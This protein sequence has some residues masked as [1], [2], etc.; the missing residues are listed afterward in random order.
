ML[1]FY[2]VL[3]LPSAAFIKTQF[4]S[5]LVLSLWTLASSALL[6]TRQIVSSS[7]PFSAG[8]IILSQHKTGSVWCDLFL[9]DPCWLLF[10]HL[11]Y[12]VGAFKLTLKWFVLVPFWT[13][14]LEWLIQ[15][16]PGLFP[17]FFKYPWSLTFTSLLQTAIFN[18]LLKVSTN[19]SQI[20]MDSFL[21]TLGST[22]L[23]PI[24][25]EIN[26][27]LLIMNIFVWALVLLIF[28]QLGKSP[29]IHGFLVNRK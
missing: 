4:P 15:N 13:L 22:A 14:E 1:Y 12:S 28:K 24:V 21:C 29:E 16:F 11:Y 6:K 8:P 23:S 5:L 9:T 3:C 17:H 26:N 27:K 2:E 20:A 25:L 19:G 10:Y 7:S 18:K